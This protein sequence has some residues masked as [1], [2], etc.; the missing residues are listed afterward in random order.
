MDF[1]GFHIFDNIQSLEELKTIHFDE[2]EEGGEDDSIKIHLSLGFG[3]MENLTPVLE[4]NYAGTPCSCIFESY[5]FTTV[6]NDRI[7][8][9]DLQSYQV[10]KVFSANTAVFHIQYDPFRNILFVCDFGFTVIHDAIDGK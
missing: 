7:H 1:S 5:L 6:G 10:I 4:D 9:I 2:E 3:S 8:L